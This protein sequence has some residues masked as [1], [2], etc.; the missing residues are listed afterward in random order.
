MRRLYGKMSGLHPSALAGDP[1]LLAHALRVPPGAFLCALR[2]ATSGRHSRGYNY[3]D[4]SLVPLSQR[5]AITLYS[6]P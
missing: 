1:G 3:R 4:A 5:K 6:D 2:E